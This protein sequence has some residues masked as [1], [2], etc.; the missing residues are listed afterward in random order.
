MVEA[1]MFLL[2]E[3]FRELLGLGYSRQHL[4]QLFH[5]LADAVETGFTT[6]LPDSF[7]DYSH[8]F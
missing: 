6:S 3:H 4:H 5:S 8:V 7:D 2:L 1:L